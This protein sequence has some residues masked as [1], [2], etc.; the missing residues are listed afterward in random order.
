MIKKLI[1][2]LLLI[3]SADVMAQTIDM[4]LIPYRKGDKWGYATADKE[5]VIQ[6]K[7][8]DAGWFSEGLAAVKIGNKY[9]YINRTGRVVIPAKYTVAKSFRKGYMPN[10]N[11]AGGDSIIFAGASLTAN[12]YEICINSKG[13]RMPQCPAIPESSIAQ[14][15]IPVEAV[16]RTKTY[17]VPNN[18]GL[19]DRIVDD[20]TIDGSTEN[21]YIAV[22]NNRY[23]VFNTKFETIVPFQYDSIKINRRG[24]TPFLEVNQNGRY[25]VVLTNGTMSIQPEN[26]RLSNINT[27]N[28]AEYMIVQKDGKTYL[29]DINNKEFMKNGYSDIVYDN[30][31]GFIITGDNNLRGYYF[32][33]DKTIEPKYKD[34]RLVD[35]TRFLQIKTS[36]G[37]TGYISSDGNEYFA[38]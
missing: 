26:T 1:V 32:I 27:N 17:N 16:T 7:F 25:G 33:D 10:K 15:N 31:G 23:G 14:N 6:P 29:R 35:G 37:K 5:I 8:K 18:N 24:K 34:I 19:F 28:G 9:G 4:T 21:Y 13:V 36:N 11:K 38:E 3:S 2:A 30:Q 12:G 20:Y 22:K